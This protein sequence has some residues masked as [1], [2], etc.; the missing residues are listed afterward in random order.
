MGWMG[1]GERG[2]LRGGKM[3]RPERGLPT[4]SSSCDLGVTCLHVRTACACMQ[5]SVCVSSQA[6]LGCR[7]RWA[8][9]R[10]ELGSGLKCRPG[11]F[12]AGEGGRGEGCRSQGGRQELRVVLGR[13]GLPGSRWQVSGASAE[14]RKPLGLH[15]GL[16]RLPR[17]EPRPAGCAVLGVCA[18]PVLPGGRVGVRR[19]SHL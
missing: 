14:L 16:S 11:D 13:P 17:W 12:W 1:N 9:A 2:A 10:A 19:G 4:S 18:G 6:L 15:D 8:E 5:I 7:C 3:E